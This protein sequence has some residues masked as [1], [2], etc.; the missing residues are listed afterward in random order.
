MARIFEPITHHKPLPAVTDDS[1]KDH[2]LPNEVERERIKFLQDENAE[3][4]RE[5]AELKSKLRDYE[6]GFDPMRW[7]NV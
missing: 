5:N 1:W 6:C 4:K 7:N 3:L 2:A